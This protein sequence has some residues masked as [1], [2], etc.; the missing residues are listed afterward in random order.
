MK[1]L[2]VR[3]MLV[4]GY[5][6]DL[7]VAEEDYTIFTFNVGDDMR[8][9]SDFH[10]TLRLKKWEDGTDVVTVVCCHVAAYYII[11]NDLTAE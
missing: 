1:A 8:S 7:Y 11:A 4:G 10:N 9:F 3:A 6:L 2:K 5:T